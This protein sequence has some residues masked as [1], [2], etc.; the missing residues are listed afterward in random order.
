LN[1]DALVTPGWLAPLMRVFEEHPDAGAVGPTLVF[2]DGRLQ[3][4]GGM[5]DRQA[6]AVQRRRG[7]RDDAGPH[8]PEV[9]DYCSAAALLVRRH[10]FESALGFDLVW[11][12]AYYE[13]CDLCLRLACGG[14]RTYY[15]SGSR[16]I[17]LEHATAGDPGQSLKCGPS[18]IEVN[19]AKFLARWSEYLEARERAPAAAVLRPNDEVSSPA[20]RARVQSSRPTSSRGRLGLYTAHALIPGGGERYL[21]TMAAAAASEFDVTLVTDV[22]YSRLR[23]LQLGRELGLELRDVARAT[24]RDRASTPPFDVFVAM[25]TAILPSTPPRGRRNIFVCQFPFSIGPQTLAERW[26]NLD[27][28]ERIVVYSEFAR[29]HTVEA[30]AQVALGVV[31]RVDIV[32]PPVA[33]VGGS[34]EPRGPVIL[35]VGRFYAGGHPKRHDMLLEAF[36][37]IR[38]EWPSAELHIAGALHPEAVHRDHLLRLQR[39]ARDLPVTFHVNPSRSALE[40]LYRRASVYWHAT[41]FDSSASTRPEHMEHFGIAVVEAMSAGCI[42]VCFA[43]GGPLEIVSHGHTGYLYETIADLRAHTLRLVADASAGWVADLRRAAM[44]ASEPYGQAV[45]AAAIRALLQEE[46][47]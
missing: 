11:E 30:M 21:L 45:F 36:E 12:P 3:E 32:A 38:R 25:D 42:P 9:V 34:D 16:V 18:L 43:A 26:G 47:S 4:A 13:D 20:G 39:R 17:H 8:L 22:P 15:C 35:S 1:N 31:P 41:G 24:L 28:Y 44:T 2:P 19:R 6:F 40:A 10:A 37:G 23:V 5:L 7:M 46:A 27:G 33:L 29:Q 14:W